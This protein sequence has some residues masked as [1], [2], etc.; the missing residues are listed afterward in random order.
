MAVTASRSAITAQ[1]RVCRNLVGR[2]NLHLRQMGFEM[3]ASELGLKGEHVTAALF[4]L[5]AQ[6]VFATNIS[7]RSR[8]REIAA[9]VLRR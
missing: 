3:N 7:R 1:L 8:P 9:R 4:E 2:Q 5:S 6:Q